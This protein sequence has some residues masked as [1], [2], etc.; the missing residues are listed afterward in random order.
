MNSAPHGTTGSNRQTPPTTGHRGGRGGGGSY[1][2]NNRGGRGGGGGYRGGRGGGG[3][4]SDRH[5][6][7]SGGDRDRDGG[8]RKQRANI[9]DLAKYM[10]KSL[11]VQFMGGREVTGVLK[12]YD[13]LTNIVLDDTVETIREITDD[14]IIEKTRQLGLVLARGTTIVLIAPTD[15]F[16]EIENPF[17]MAE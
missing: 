6:G 4:H 2:N 10:D 14:A 13:Q 3:H 5:H 12:G 16:E 9:L 17:V 1:H 11:H 7:G 8:E 15:G